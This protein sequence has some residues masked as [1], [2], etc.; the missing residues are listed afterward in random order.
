MENQSPK[1][2]TIALLATGTIRAHAAGKSPEDLQSDIS[3]V[4]EKVM[5]E[6][7]S[8]DE[9]AKKATPELPPNTKAPGDTPRKEI[10]IP[11]PPQG[12]TAPDLEHAPIVTMAPTKTIR[13][14]IGEEIT[15][16]GAAKGQTK[17]PEKIYFAWILNGVVVCQQQ[18]CR[19][20]IDGKLLSSGSHQLLFV[21]YNIQGSSISRHNLIVQKSSWSQKSP[22]RSKTIESEVVDVHAS[23]IEP[24][25]PGKLNISM[26][27]GNAV[28]AYPEN[29]IVVGSVARNLPWEGQIKTAPRG[30]ARI[31]DPKFGKIFLLGNGQVNFAVDKDAKNLRSIVI[32][33]GIVR[34]QSN[35]KA[36][37]KKKIERNDILIGTKEVNVF[38]DPSVDVAIVRIAPPAD[39]TR[40]RTGARNIAEVAKADQYQTRLVSISGTVRFQLPKTAEK[41]A[42]IATIPP[43]VELVVFEDGKIG[44]FE[45][46]KPDFMEKL[47]HQTMTPEEIRERARRKAEALQKPVDIE[48][49]L[50]KVEDL[51][52]RSDY[53]EMLNELAAVEDRKREDPRISYNLGIAYKGLYQPLEAEKHFR[54]AM[55][56]NSDYADPAWQLALMLLDEKKWAD[57]NDVFSDARSR[58]KSDDKRRTEYPYYSGV[59]Q[60]GIPSDFS[61]RNSFSRALLWEDNLEQSLKAS[62]GDFLKKLRERKDWSVI[63]PLGVQWEGNTLGLTSDAILPPG[64]TQKNVLRSIA[65]AMFSWDPSA[66][67]EEPG[68]YKGASATAMYAKHYPTQFKSF[69]SIILGT[70]VSQIRKT[71]IE[72]PVPE[73]KKNDKNEKPKTEIRTLKFSE[74]VNASIIDGNFQ[75]LNIGAGVNYLEFNSTLGYER[76][77]PKGATATGTIVG[78]EQYALK[79]WQNTTGL[80]ADLDSASEQRLALATSNTNGHSFSATLTPSF[81]IPFSVLTNAKIGVAFGAKKIFYGAETLSLNSATSL[82]LTRFITPWLVGI[83]TVGYELVFEKDSQPTDAAS[84]LIKKP[85]AGLMLSGLF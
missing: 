36:D 25:D 45:R 72:V 64:Y 78:A 84:R 41:P 6:Q 37:P 55:T 40:R 39:A 49:I 65:G 27:Q 76:N 2:L 66:T 3:T 60:F 69:N 56:Q 17:G 23:K 32:D 5:Q 9:R 18:E 52:S 80:T 30:V 58:M 11:V 31:T 4:S 21:A 19:I 33:K 29:V 10:D 61:A 43:G 35:E 71:S 53:F 57:A 15:L 74:N 7:K 22:Y 50:K 63:I 73:D 75:L 59:A 82:A 20:P 24:L 46:P 26:M 14:W 1:Y 34:A 8:F 81:T 62:S 85:S 79:L 42:S 38:V 67:R 70:G 83:G 12:N 51:A 77:S 44:P 16:K 68:W 28:H 54:F 48:A 47:I 13:A